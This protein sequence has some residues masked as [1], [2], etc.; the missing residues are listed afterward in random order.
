MLQKQKRQGRFYGGICAAAAVVLLPHG[1]LDAGPAT[2]YSSYESKMTKVDYRP[3]ERVVVNGTCVTSH[4]P[5]TAIEI[6]LKLVELIYSKEKT[7]SVAPDRA[8]PCIPR[9]G[10]VHT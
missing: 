8:M 9:S 5:G 6:G 2:K 1:L 3:K 4:G 10:S 7:K